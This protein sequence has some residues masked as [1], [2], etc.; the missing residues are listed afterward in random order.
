VSQNLLISPPL[1]DPSATAAAPVVQMHD[2][3]VFVFTR[4]TPFTTHRRGQWQRTAA[5][6]MFV[7]RPTCGRFEIWW[8]RPPYRRM[9][10]RDTLPPRPP[11]ECH[12]THRRTLISCK[13]WTLTQGL[14]I[15]PRKW[16]D[17][18]RVFAAAAD[19]EG[20]SRQA[21]LDSACRHDPGLRAAVD[22]LLDAHKDAGSFGDTPLFASPTA[23]KRL[24]P[25]SQLGPF[26]IESLLGAGGMGE[27]YRAHDTKLHR[28]VAIK[29]LPDFFAQRPDRLARFEEEARAL[30]A[31]N[32]PRVGAI[33][34]L[35]ESTGVA[36]L[37]LE[38]VEGATLAERLAGPL[39]FDE[40]VRI[41]RQLAEGLEAAH[42]RG[43]VHRDL[44]PANIKITP[45]GNVKILDFG[46]A[47]TAGSP[48]D[49]A[50]TPATSSPRDATQSGTVLGTVG[51]MSPEQ[52]RGQAVD[53]RTDIWAFGCVLFEMCAHQPPFAGATISDA[54]TAVVER[55]PAWELLR[56]DT[57]ADVV[58]LLRRCL[59]KDPR[60]RLPDI[61]EARV[62]LE[63][64]E[65]AARW[66]GARVTSVLIIVIAAIAAS[67]AWLFVS[68]RPPSVSTI[69]VL[70]FTRTTAGEPSEL[71]AGL[72]DEVI[73]ALG[74]IDPQ[75]LRPIARRSII[76]YLAAGKSA[77]Q[78]GRDLNAGYLLDGVMS[79]QGESW[80][81][82]FTV[83]NVREQ[84][85]YPL[86]EFVYDRS[87][88]P[89]LQTELARAI[90]Q[91]I[92]L[93]LSARQDQALV[94]RQPRNPQA[95]EHYLLGRSLWAKTSGDAL[96]EAIEEYKRAIAL[97]PNYALAYAGLAEAYT[98]LPI[99][100]DVPSSEVAGPAR[101]AATQAVR[102]D[103]QL[104]EAHAALGW[105]EFWLGWNWPE[106]YSSL[107]DAT[108]LDPNYASAH[109][110][111]GH[112]LSNWGRH[113]EA[114]TEMARA[115]ALDPY[116]PTMDMVSAQTAYNSRDFPSAAVYARQS[117]A[118]A[119]DFWAGYAQLGQALAGQGDF[120]K[121]LGPAFKSYALAP[122]AK[123][124]WAAY[125]LGRMGQRAEAQKFLRE[126]EQKHPGVAP[127]EVAVVHAGLNDAEGVFAAL[128]RAY[129]VHDVNL[130]F[131]P[132]DPK[133]DPFRSDLRFQRLLDRCGFT[134]ARR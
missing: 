125:V 84:I 92:R 55:E 69:A 56:P 6:M 61:G 11:A 120:E 79:E 23:V 72:H 34:G 43:I 85:E 110:Q 88:L 28:D 36:A 74:Q 16:P 35:E 87:T 15:D 97:D 54:L 68:S 108:M 30:A 86:K 83:T 89:H 121:A 119:P 63:R 7:C 50:V 90:A 4:R 124:L 123:G 44:K 112:V 17:I 105:Q 80:H 9:D 24:S 95:Y 100:A 122:N 8:I 60:L 41:A 93:Q 3:V 59:T 27:V 75:R 114:L 117:I 128:D 14:D 70:P 104:A 102:A 71:G 126:F 46:L 22:S 129:S 96:R 10:P 5:L 38:L 33:Y 91:Q 19:L 73:T 66:P 18:S 94:R 118:K 78:I 109:R 39:P 26:R 58:R 53:K 13:I 116:S 99:T 65:P 29:V 45:D 98:L 101:E 48:P 76:A 40:V 115:R 37:V 133:M 42:Q 64:A 52:A 31:L 67:A 12:G 25:G 82:T 127:Y 131:L 20:P 21:Y 1:S 81:F 2:V 51:Y 77:G 107:R 49:A 103:D 62:A 134:R 130:V 132:V 57:P 111:L 106:A 32:H 113:S 47:N